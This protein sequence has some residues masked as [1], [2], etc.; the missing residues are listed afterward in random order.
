MTPKTQDLRCFP[1]RLADGTPLLA[2]DLEVAVDATV[3]PPR[4]LAAVT[5]EDASI[6]LLEDSGELGP[7]DL[8]PQDD[9]AP[10]HLRLDLEARPE[11]VAAHA[12]ALTTVADP[13]HYLADL[14]PDSPLYHLSAWE[15]IGCELLV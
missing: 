7:L 13:A 2:Y 14:P 10:Y 15:V 4:L 6:E 12:E 1:L 5:L 3:D 8:P 11:P 9:L